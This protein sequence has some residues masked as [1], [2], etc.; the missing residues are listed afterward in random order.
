YQAAYFADYW[1]RCVATSNAVLVRGGS[2][3]GG[4]IFR[5]Q[6]CAFNARVNVLSAMLGGVMT[7]AVYA[8]ND[9]I[10]KTTI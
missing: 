1:Q 9:K 7:R 4:W 10:H 2:W 8:S 3:Y 5:W 6:A